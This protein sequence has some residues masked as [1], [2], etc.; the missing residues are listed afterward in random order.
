MSALPA[1]FRRVPLA[2]R[3]LHDVDEGRP[4]NSCAA[5]RAAMDAGYGIEID[6][7]LSRDGRAMVFH[8]YSLDRLTGEK[9]AIQ[10]RDAAEL[11]RILL[12]GGDEG[13][14]TFAQ[15]LE[16]VAGRVPLLIELKDQH[17]QMGVTDERLEKAVAADLA[18]YSGPVGLM[19]FNPNSVMSLAGLV[20]DL[21]RGIVTEAYP[22]EHWRLLKPEVRRRLRNIPDFDR[23]GASFIS[24]DKSDL[25]NPRVA[26]L[27]ARGATILCWTIRSREQE[28]EARKVAHNITFEGYLAEIPS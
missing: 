23:V 9:G 24:H 21:P 4:E 1:V 18:G 13:I 27:K 28:T 6:L 2:H 5:I 25:D 11:G 26:E 10:Q 12:T 3:A 7:Q 15:V 22:A 20:P 16:L 14:P 19:S 8:D 17:G